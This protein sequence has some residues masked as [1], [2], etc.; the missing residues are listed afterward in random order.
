[1]NVKCPRCEALIPVAAPDKPWLRLVIQD[2]CPG[3]GEEYISEAMRGDCHPAED[4]IT[5]GLNEGNG[6]AN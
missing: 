4:D 1:M 5:V 6:E 3:C 2:K